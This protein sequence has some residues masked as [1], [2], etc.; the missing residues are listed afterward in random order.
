MR[1]HYQ[2]KKLTKAQLRKIFSDGNYEARA[3]RGE[4]HQE[5][6]KSAHPSPPRANEPICTLSQIIAYRDSHGKKV[7][8]I[9]R[10]LRTDGTIGAGGHPD[11]KTILDG[12]TL[13]TL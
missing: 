3:Q 1:H 11:P 9:H 10:Y 2:I 7:A 13:F 6:M 12:D 8:I 5:I 4:L